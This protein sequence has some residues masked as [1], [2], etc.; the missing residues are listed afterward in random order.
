MNDTTRKP[1]GI[2]LGMRVQYVRKGTATGERVMGEGQPTAWLCVGA[3]GQVIELH[4]GYASHRCPD[5]HKD[6]DCV[7]GG[8]QAERPGFVGEMESWGTVEY[9]TDIP[10][11][12]IKRAILPS[13]KGKGWKP[14]KS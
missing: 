9:E 5:H 12:T 6:P 4:P 14:L 2:T 13:E 10:G 7:C 11:R 8:D 1:A 3:I